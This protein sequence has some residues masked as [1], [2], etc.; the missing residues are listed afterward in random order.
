MAEQKPES[1]AGDAPRDPGTPDAAAQPD[2]AANVDQVL[3]ATEASMRELADAVADVV[4]EAGTDVADV[5]GVAGVAG[6]IDLLGDVDLDVV[7]EL[8]RTEMLVEDVLKLASGSVV[9]LDKL[10]G[11]PVDVRVNGRL[12]ARGE[13]LVL[14]D[15]FCIRISEVLA[16]LEEEAQALAGTHPGE[17][18]QPVAAV[19]SDGA[20]TSGGGGAGAGV[21]EEAR[22][23]PAAESGGD[24]KAE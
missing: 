11:D 23:K 19:A 17:P 9:E 18:A 3:D 13:V 1:E 6:G 21:G 14:N 20:G 16:D 12:V 22:A 7:I 15:N 5:A 8:G 2:P 24:A 4:P 10:A